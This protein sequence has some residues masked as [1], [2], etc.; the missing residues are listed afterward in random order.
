MRPLLSDDGNVIAEA[1]RLCD[2]GANHNA[3]RTSAG[4]AG[5]VQGRLCGRE[6]LAETMARENQ[7]QYDSEKRNRRQSA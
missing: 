6:C 4:G 5:V 3:W 2:A 1:D 7:R